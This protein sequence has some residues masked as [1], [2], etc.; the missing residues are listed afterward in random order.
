[1]GSLWRGLPMKVILRFLTF[2]AVSGLPLMTAAEESSTELTV[3]IPA[4]P[5]SN[6]SSAHG[7]KRACEVLFAVD[8]VLWEKR[9]RNMTYLVDTAKFLVNKLNGIFIPQIFTKPFDDL[10]FRLARVQVV[11]GLCDVGFEEEKNCTSQRGQ[12]LNNFDS[13]RDFS[14]FCLAHVFTYRDFD[15]GTAGLASVGTVCRPIQNSGFVTSLNHGLERSLEETV[16]TYAHEVAHNFNAN[17][18]D[19]LE[20]SENEDINKYFDVNCT[21]GN[22]IMSGDYDLKAYDTPQFSPCSTIA[23]RDKLA[24]LR[25]DGVYETCFKEISADSEE[26][27]VTEPEVSLCGN[28]IVDPGEECDCGEDEEHCYDPCCFPARVL[29]SD[30]ENDPER[31]VWVNGEKKTKPSKRLSCT[32]HTLPRCVNPPALVYGIYVPLAVIAIVFGVLFVFLRRDW[33]H[34]RRCFEHITRGNVRIIKPATA[35]GYHRAAAPALPAAGGGGG[36][37]HP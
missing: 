12:F 27:D 28:H 26:E 3:D 7:R 22:Y 11:F 32:R 14:D 16:A 25:S 17:H 37:L 15:N 6:H 20:K 5:P 18:D 23:M 2:L 34:Q 31:V 4:I 19:E 29:V 13:P 35:Q 21:H 33:K 8:D 24:A 1:M 36:S 30:K 10:Y 9:N